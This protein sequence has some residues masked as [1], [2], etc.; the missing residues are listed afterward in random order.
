MAHQKFHSLIFISRWDRHN[1]LPTAPGPG[2]D[3]IL[4]KLWGQTYAASCTVVICLCWKDSHWLQPFHL[5]N[6]PPLYC[7]NRHTAIPRY[8]FIYIVRYFLIIMQVP[9]A[10]SSQTAEWHNLLTWLDGY[11]LVQWAWL[12]LL[13]I[14]TDHRVREIQTWAHRD[15]KEATYVIDILW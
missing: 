2:S 9:S 11:R 14:Q 7:P 8:H 12:L 10:V 1:T 6:P 5:Q 15:F 13:H 3:D 4:Y